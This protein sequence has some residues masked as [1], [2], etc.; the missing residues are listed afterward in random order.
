MMQAG[1]IK[2]AFRAAALALLVPATACAGELEDKIAYCKCCHGAHGQG[3]LGA[4]TIPRLAGQQVPYME[5]VFKALEKHTRDN[6]PATM[7]MIPSERSIK[8]GMHSAIAKYFNGLEARPAED[9][10]RHLVAEGK[11]IYDEGVPSAN[12]P[13]CTTCHGADAKGSEA[14]P[15]LAGQHYSYLVGQLTGWNEGYRSK[16]PVK[17]DAPNSMQAIA[18]GLTKE[19]MA[20]VAA[21]LSF[22]M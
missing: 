20:A 6:P 14:A 22:A 9:G 10:P 18:A 21:Y 13:A 2:S 1:K 16:D 3:Y 17:S 8:P 7:F 11:K 12:V 5:N 4:F 19:Q 15:S